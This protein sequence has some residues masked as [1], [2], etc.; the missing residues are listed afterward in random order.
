MPYYPK[1]QIKTDLFTKGGEF[2]VKTTKKEYI[3]YYWKT[4][5]GEFFS[6]K[7]PSFPSPLT[8]EK[9]PLFSP[10]QTSTLA[11]SKGNTSYNN[12]KKVDTSTPLLLPYY[13]KP[14]PTK[15]DYEL[16]SFT[17]FF[18]KKFNENLYIETSQN[19]Y[20]K[21]KNKNSSYAYKLY[22]TFTLN[23]RLTGS[24]IEVT[25]TNKN[26]ILLTEQTLNIAG[27]SVYLKYNYTEFIL[28]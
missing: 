17:R 15:K 16:G 7:N 20:N 1:S 5:K 14:S 28:K 2:R 8:L 27:L 9:I 23:W 11:I 10:L 21:L 24:I 19:I 25:N 4:S 26:L 22:L 3:G 18:A 12:L 13:V 6:G